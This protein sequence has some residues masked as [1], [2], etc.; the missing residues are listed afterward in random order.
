M[1]TQTQQ[2]EHTKGE[3]RIEEKSFAIADTGDYDGAIDVL[4]EGQ[5][6]P[7]VRIDYNVHFRSDE[8]NMA[9]AQ[10]IVKAVNMHDE[11]VKT[12]KQIS[13]ALERDFPSFPNA[14]GWGKAKELIK[15][16]EQQ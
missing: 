7:I 1:K 2:P 16:A 4:A 12:L 15:Q 10:R 13:E 9:N 11:L 14:M 3:W 6:L 5:E 8:E